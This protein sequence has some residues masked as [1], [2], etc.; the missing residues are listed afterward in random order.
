MDLCSAYDG[1][2]NRFKLQFNLNTV[3]ASTNNGLH[4]RNKLFISIKMKEKLRGSC[5]QVK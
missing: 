2:N 1:C 4:L 5:N 3:R